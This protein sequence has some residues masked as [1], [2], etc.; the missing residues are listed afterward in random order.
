MEI[1][2]RGANNDLIAR[3]VRDQRQKRL[4]KL[5]R[6]VGIFVHLPVGGDESLSRH[7]V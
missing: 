1:G 5:P 6:L 4:E 2:V 3:V 7:S